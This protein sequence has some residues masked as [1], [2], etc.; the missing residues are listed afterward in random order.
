MGQW[1]GVRQ[2]WGSTHQN[3]FWPERQSAPRPC[4]VVGKCGLFWACVSQGAVEMW[5]AGALFAVLVSIEKLSWMRAGS[6]WH[7][8]EMLLRCS[9]W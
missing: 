2:Q 7:T 9:D 8:S 1:H 4:V 3:S 5:H 6:S